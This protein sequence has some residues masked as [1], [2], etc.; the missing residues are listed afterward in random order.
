MKSHSLSGS[1]FFF[2]IKLLHDCCQRSLEAV[3]LAELVLEGVDLA[4]DLA[5]QGLDDLVNV[6]LEVLVLGLVLLDE[7]VDRVL[8]LV[9]LLVQL[10]AQ[11]PDVA[12]SDASHLVDCAF[13]V[14][15]CITIVIVGSGHKQVNFVLLDRAGLLKTG[16]QVIHE[17]KFGLRGIHVLVLHDSLKSVAHDGDQHVQHRDLSD[18]CS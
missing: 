6:G 17:L 11:V 13:P 10:E 12:R 18:E 15:T 1:F 4:K 9:V 8:Q 2:L 7:V 5:S 16:D 3:N 14:I